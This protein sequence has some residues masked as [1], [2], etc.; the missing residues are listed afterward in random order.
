MKEKKRTIA[1]YIKTLIV[2]CILYAY[3]YN[4]LVYI[5]VLHLQSLS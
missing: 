2:S 4:I 5:Y 1:L 3:I